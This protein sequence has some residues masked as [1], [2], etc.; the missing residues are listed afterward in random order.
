MF[1][2][3]QAQHLRAAEPDHDERKNSPL[4]GEWVPLTATCFPH[5][6]VALEYTNAWGHSLGELSM[7]TAQQHLVLRPD[8][9]GTLMTPEEFD[10]ADD[11]DELYVYE[12]IHGV[13]VVTPERHREQ[14]NEGESSNEELRPCKDCTGK[15]WTA[16]ADLS[17]E[18]RDVFRT[19]GR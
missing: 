15:E 13:L 7:S 16:W 3:I 11:C 14:Q 12:L 1:H 9:A 6:A 2:E 8:L 5:F 4:V 17:D 10:S 19:G 18:D